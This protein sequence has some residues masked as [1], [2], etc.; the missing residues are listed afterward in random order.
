MI[1]K[2]HPLLHKHTVHDHH[3]CVLPAFVNVNAFSTTT[4]RNQTRSANRGMDLAKR[5]VARQYRFVTH[6]IGI[7]SYH[8]HT[9]SFTVEYR[10]SMGLVRTEI[11]NATCQK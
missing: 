5:D 1:R 2:T 9:L 3:S 11:F 8:P 7:N 6:F 10:Y 4:K